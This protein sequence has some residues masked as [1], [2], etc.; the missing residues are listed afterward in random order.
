[1]RKTTSS[2]GRCLCRLMLAAGTVWTATLPLAAQDTAELLSRMKAMEDRIKSLE[3][4][5]ATLKGRPPHRRRPP[6]RAWAARRPLP[7]RS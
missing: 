7:P 6:R 1:M 5:V 4:E 3:A 2:V